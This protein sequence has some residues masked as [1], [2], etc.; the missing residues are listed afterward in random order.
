[1]KHHAWAGP[2]LME[3]TLLIGVEVIR[4]LSTEGLQEKE[5]DIFTI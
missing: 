5:V 1:M 2:S 3:I 4:N